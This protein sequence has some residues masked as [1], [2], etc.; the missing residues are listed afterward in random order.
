MVIGDFR[1]TCLSWTRIDVLG[2]NEQITVIDLIQK[3]TNQQEQKQQLF[4]HFRFSKIV[5]PVLLQ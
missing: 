3:A 5:L 1:T 2:H 4:F